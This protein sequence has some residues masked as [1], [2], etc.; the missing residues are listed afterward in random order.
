MTNVTPAQ[1]EFL[2]SIDTPTKDQFDFL[3]SID[4]PTV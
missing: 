1:F 4:T 3:R 2:R